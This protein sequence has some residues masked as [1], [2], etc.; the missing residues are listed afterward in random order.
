MP[1]ANFRVGSAGYSQALSIGNAM[2]QKEGITLRIIPAAGTVRPNILGILV[3]GVLTTCGLLLAFP[4]PV[5]SIIGL[6]M[7]TVTYGLV[8][9]AARAGLI[10]LNKVEHA[11]ELGS[12]SQT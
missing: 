9:A 10:T 11:L 6:G 12:R 5:T 4:E 1:A 8:L 7:V 3:R 2:A